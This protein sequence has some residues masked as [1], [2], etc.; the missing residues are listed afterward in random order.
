MPTF[1]EALAAVSEEDA[2]KIRKL[3]KGAVDVAAENQG[4]PVDFLETAM[5]LTMAHGGNCPLDLDRM[6]QDLE[7]GET[8]SIGH[9]IHG[10]ARH[11]NRDNGEFTACFWPRYAR[12]Q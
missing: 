10:I 9:D 11:L 3:V 7:A 4:S 2:A 8:S 5:D 6:L 1:E 12:E